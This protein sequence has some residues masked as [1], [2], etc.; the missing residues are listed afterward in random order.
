[1]HWSR[2]L[3]SLDLSKAS[4]L[5]LAVARESLQLRATQTVHSRWLIAVAASLTALAMSAAGSLGNALAW[6]LPV[7]F[8]AQWNARMCQQ[9]LAGLNDAD[10]QGLT[11]YQ[12]QLWRMAFV[13]QTLVGLG[14]W[15]M[16]GDNSVAAAGFCTA[17]Q[18]VYVGAAMVNGS[19]HPPTFIAGAF[20]NLA[21]TAAFWL[22]Q[23]ASG[24]AMA[25]GLLGVGLVMAKQSQ[26][27][28]HSF[29][30]SMRM[31]FEN[32]ELLDKLAAEKRV[33]EAATEFKSNFLATI[34]HEIRTPISAI[35]GMSYLTLKTELNST[36][37]EYVELVQ[38]GAQHLTEL[39]NQ[40]LDF[41]KVEAHM[42]A[43]EH[44]PF[45]L[46]KVLDNACALNADKA[47][48]QGLHLHCERASDV[49]DHLVGDAMRLG[50]VLMNYISNAIKFTPSGGVTVRCSLRER[51][52]QR[53]L[54]YFSV[55]DS[56][57][58]LSEEAMG[59]VFQSFQQAEASTTRR[60]GGTGLGLAIAKKMAELM[61]GEVGVHSSPGAGSTFWFTAW[62]DVASED[63]QDST[64][65]L[66]EGASNHQ[67]W[68]AAVQGDGAEPLVVALPALTEAAANA[69]APIAALL[70]ASDAQALWL[71]HKDAPGLQPTLGAGYA[72]LDKAMGSYDWAS[73]QRLLRQWGVQAS[74][75]PRPNTNQRTVLVVDDTPVNVTLL[76]TLL[77]PHYRV[78]ACTNGQ[79][80]LVV[81][82]EQQPHVILLDVMMPEMDGYTVC[83]RLKSSV[84][85][86]DI[87]VIFVTA[88]SQPTDEE[89]GL[90]LGAADYISKPISP[91]I[92][93]AR[94]RTQLAAQA[95]ANF[96]KDKAQYLKKEVA[97]QT[98]EIKRI[99]DATIVAMASMAETRD[100]ETGA[101]ILRTQHY[102][103]TLALHLQKHPRFCDYLSDTQIDLLFKSAPLHDIGK[104]GIPDR[105]LHK[106]S[107]LDAD[108]M[109][110]MKTHT[111]I[112]RNII[113]I[114]ERRL[115]HSVPFLA[116]AKEIAYGHQEK[117]DGSG[118]PL[119]LAGDA[120]TISARLMAVAD[121]YDAL[122]SPR[123]YKPAFSH[124][125]AR[126]LILAGRGLHFDPDIVDA[127]SALEG[128]FQRIATIYTD[129]AL[130][131]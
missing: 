125:K 119:G 98:D 49:P 57:I 20:A 2:F 25:V 84:Q 116:C 26:Q 81:A 86:Q 77:S 89:M 9:V 68:G 60:Y 38:Q 90:R 79:R 105:I 61:G 108:E 28:A 92:V 51:Q 46:H 18:L 101:H 62:F 114:A 95:A 5:G 36:Q 8:M 39:V 43:L 82:K 91:P 72:L 107:R 73:A 66:F 129:E 7:V 13:N 44:D 118:Y 83:K 64:L 52:G 80:A 56:G 19:T 96:L 70:D 71:W 12:W 1:M 42:L 120:I 122:I 111:T 121:V 76:H 103:Q 16:A 59:R 34:S 110:V 109:E 74:A 15:W 113:E 29:S 35:L 102:V 23:G 4:P 63:Q 94:V 115:G 11:R 104:V 67:A 117:W 58:G 41:S 75:L 30:E 54:L 87:P 53:V 123:V 37:R 100:N 50:S 55:Q 69:L 65:P 130:S 128:E 112:G 124:A 127:F 6:V 32:V 31:R 106:P 126:D 17:V 99:Q 93:L 40:V 47:V 78:L 33:A 97:R 14:V 3:E 131:P 10:A 27:M 24:G 85:T 45:T 22:T 48:A 88:R 21:L